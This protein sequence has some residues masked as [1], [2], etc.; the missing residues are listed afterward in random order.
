MGS[1][2]TKYSLFEEGLSSVTAFAKIC[3]RNPV[4]FKTEEHKKSVKKFSVWPFHSEV[5]L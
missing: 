5:S 1:A 4:K 3:A 2:F